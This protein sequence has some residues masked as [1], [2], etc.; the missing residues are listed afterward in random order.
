MNAPKKYPRPARTGLVTVI[1]IGN[2]WPSRCRP[3]HLEPLVDDRRVAG[4]VE[5]PQALLV[6]GAEI[7][8][9]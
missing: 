2:S 3:A 9:A 1:S 5:A 4:L 7:R 6:R 8:A